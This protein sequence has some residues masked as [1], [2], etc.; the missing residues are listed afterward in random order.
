MLI[1]WL[2]FGVSDLDLELGGEREGG[3]GSF[4]VLARPAF[5]SSVI[6]SFLPE[7][8]GPKPP[9]PLP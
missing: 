9:R 4:A 7:M 6:S 8:R 2:H 1:L 3:R 5:L